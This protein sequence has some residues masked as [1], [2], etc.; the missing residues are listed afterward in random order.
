MALQNEKAD[1]IKKE[2]TLKDEMEKIKRYHTT[3]QNEIMH[4]YKKLMR[5][6][7]H[8]K[9]IYEKGIFFSN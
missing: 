5:E 8:L 7:Q 9:K 2:T 1:L 6:Y 3:K 4:Q